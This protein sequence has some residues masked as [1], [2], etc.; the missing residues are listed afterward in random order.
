MEYR[1]HFSI[2]LFSNASHKVRSSN[3]LA[4]FT[5]QLAQRID[6]GSTDNWEVGLCELSCPPPYPHTVKPYEPVGERNALIYC[7]LITQKFVG[8][9]YV[10]CL[11]TFIHP[12]K[13]CDHA[14]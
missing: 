3:T 9:D 6:L 7:D 4:E 8:S 13:Y 11:R 1:K 10:R 14:F 2:T 12:S 5:I